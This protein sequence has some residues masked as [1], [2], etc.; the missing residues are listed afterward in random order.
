MHSRDFPNCFFLG[1]TQTGVSINF[2]HSLIEQTQH[3]GY[4]I[5]EAERR[6]VVIEATADA[7]ERWVDTT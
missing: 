7:E 3:V 2:V 5:A 6:R 1:V 4:C